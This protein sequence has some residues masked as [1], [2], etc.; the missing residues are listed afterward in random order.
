MGGLAASCLGQG[1]GAEQRHQGP[2]ELCTRREWLT[3]NVSG[4][5]GGQRR[6][7]GMHARSSAARRWWFSSLHA[8]RPAACHIVLDERRNSSTVV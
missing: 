8:H 1:L 3:L 4:W 7:C 5:M 2:T 6:D